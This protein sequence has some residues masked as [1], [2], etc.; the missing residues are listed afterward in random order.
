MRN[1]RDKSIMEVVQTF[2]EYGLDVYNIPSDLID[3]VKN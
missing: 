3:E 1:F 2:R